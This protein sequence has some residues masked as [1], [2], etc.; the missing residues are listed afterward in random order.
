MNP[1]QPP[2]IPAVPR[3]HILVVED[4]P[5]IRRLCQAVLRRQGHRVDAAG[6]GQ[7]GW[8][9]LLAAHAAFDPFGLLITDNDMPHLTGVELVERLR[10]A[11]IEI[12][13]IMVSGMMP[14]DA[15][16]LGLAALLW[17]PFLP[18]QLTDAV[19]LAVEEFRRIQR[20][21]VHAGAAA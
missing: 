20:L 18:T 15:Q 10:C 14:L 17:K 16:S 8:E 1:T 2:E 3:Q 19:G 12:P 9:R 11:H 7:D 5:E 4:D 21:P 13:T 6:D